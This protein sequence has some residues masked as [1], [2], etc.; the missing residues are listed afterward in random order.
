MSGCLAH[1]S[2]FLV[3]TVLDGDDSVPCP[4]LAN[5]LEITPL[6]YGKPIWDEYWTIDDIREKRSGMTNDWF[7]SGQYFNQFIGTTDRSFKREWIQPYPDKMEGQ[8][9][10]GNT[11]TFNPRSVDAFTLARLLRLHITIGIDAA[12]GKKDQKGK[13]DHSGLFVLGQLPDRSGAF[14]LDGFREKLSSEMLAPHIINV[15]TK[16]MIN[17]NMYNGIFNVGHEDE[18]HQQHLGPLLKAIQRERGVETLFTVRAVP[19][20]N[21]AKW[22]RVDLLATPYS[23]GY[24]YWPKEMMVKRAAKKGERPSLYDLRPMLEAEYLNFNRTS[25]MDDLIDA[26]AIAWSISLPTAWK[27]DALTMPEGKKR[28]RYNREEAEEDVDPVLSYYDG[29]GEVAF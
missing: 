29:D 27:E 10:Q 3:A 16:W 18:P 23:N 2:S 12:S 13:L 7:W 9:D 6:G 4:P 24:F 1:D 22:A 19:H 21:E 14:W 8:D 15:T 5:G 20:G 25:T 11:V 17:T 28:G 26:H